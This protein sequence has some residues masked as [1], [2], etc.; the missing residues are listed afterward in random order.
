[1]VR[2]GEEGT[3]ACW[4][5]INRLLELS[6]Q[7]IAAVRHIHAAVML[8]PGICWRHAISEGYFLGGSVGIPD[9][10]TDF[11]CMEYL[12]GIYDTRSG[13]FCGIAV[14]PIGPLKQIADFEQFS[15]L[16]RLHG[17]SALSN[18]FTGFF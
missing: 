11:L 18:H 9:D 8:C 15:V 14:V 13:G 16:P 10:G 6:S 4:S 5:N 3:R 12:K 1:M 2:Q 7:R 17:Q